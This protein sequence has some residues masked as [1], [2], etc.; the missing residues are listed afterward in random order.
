MK[1]KLL[2]IG[3]MLTML[4]IVG[5]DGD[6]AIKETLAQRTF[7]VGY[8]GGYIFT[9]NAAV[10]FLTGTLTA[11]EIDLEQ[12]VE[13]NWMASGEPAM[14]KVCDSLGVEYDSVLSNILLGIYTHG[15]SAGIVEGD[16]YVREDFLTD[17]T[18]AEG[19]EQE[20]ARQEFLLIR[21]ELMMQ[22]D[23]VAINRK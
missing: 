4:V 1:R 13:D 21:D 2:V 10:H 12:E 9:L 16:R 19:D 6:R 7:E 22:M 18:D 23:G 3:L 20:K 15:F 8:V 17:S 5:C 14:I 11:S